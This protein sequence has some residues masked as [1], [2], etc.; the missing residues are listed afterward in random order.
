[1]F[2]RRILII[3]DLNPKPVISL[4]TE[5]YPT[6]QVTR[7]RGKEEVRQDLQDCAPEH[8][9]LLLNAH[10]RFN[11]SDYRSNFLGMRFLR[12]EFRARWRRREAVVVYS[13]LDPEVFLNIPLNQILSTSRGHY[14]YQIIRLREIVDIVAGAQPIATDADLEDIIERYGGLGGLVRLFRH[15]LDQVVRRF[16]LRITEADWETVQT[17][18]AGMVARIHHLV[19]ELVTVVPRRFHA[20]FQAEQLKTDAHALI[21][22]VKVRREVELIKHATSILD[23]IDTYPTLCKQRF[24]AEKSLPESEAI[25]GGSELP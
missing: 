12:Q 15:D 25:T 10:I 1:M 22:G 17:E 5:A 4:L 11:D 21:D 23:I 19:D 14:Y 3:D 7:L 2:P 16:R 13:S 20:E 6:A 8:T 24:S 18:G 9:V